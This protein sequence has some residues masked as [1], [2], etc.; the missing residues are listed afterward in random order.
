MSGRVS[1]EA[2][3]LS[4]RRG[5]P[6]VPGEEICRGKKKEWWRNG[7]VEYNRLRMN[8]LAAKWHGA[9]AGRSVGLSISDRRRI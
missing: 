1:H 2:D 6:G 4:N 8:G 7:A 3:G 5:V 9:T